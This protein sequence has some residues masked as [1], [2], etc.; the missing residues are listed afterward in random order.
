MNGVMNNG[1][2]DCLHPEQNSQHI[3]LSELGFIFN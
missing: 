1:L 3:K 2:E